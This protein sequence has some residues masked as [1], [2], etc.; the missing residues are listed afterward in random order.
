MSDIFEE[1]KIGSEIKPIGDT[2]KF[3]SELKP[4]DWLWFIVIVICCAAVVVGVAALISN[5]FKSNL[6]SGKVYPYE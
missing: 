5:G 6:K 2:I 1:S 4:I 3:F